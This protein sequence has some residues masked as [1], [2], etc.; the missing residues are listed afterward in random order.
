MIMSSWFGDM[1]R[2]IEMYCERTSAAWDAEPLNA[3]SNAAF[4]IA[5]WAAWRL[6]QRH[7]NRR[8]QWRNP[9][10][11]HHHRRGRSRQPDIPYRRNPLG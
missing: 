2:A 7:P 4:F 1:T 5:A 6:N 8:I 10:A 9:G 11:L 3:V